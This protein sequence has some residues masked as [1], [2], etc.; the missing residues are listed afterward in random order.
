MAVIGI[1]QTNNIGMK[2]EEDNLQV[3]CV[4]WCRMQ[5]P[6]AIIHH[7]PNGG[8]RASKLDKYGNRFSPEAIRLK[9]MGTIAGFPDLLIITPQ[10]VVF[11]ELKSAKGYQND[12]QRKMQIHLQT[13]GYDYAVC[14]SL[15]EFMQSVMTRLQ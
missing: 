8:R 5:Y 13:L 11:I 4:R 10:K 3:V 1:Q 9:Q 14:R 6:A 15:D 12:N 2:H 7:S